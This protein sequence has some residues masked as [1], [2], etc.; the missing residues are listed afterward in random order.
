MFLARRISQAKWRPNPW[1]REGE[2]SADAITA[3]L[4]T[5]RNSLS[6]WQCGSATMTEL[7][8]AVLA[9]VA[10]GQHINTIDLVWIEDKGLEAD[11]LNWEATPGDTPVTALRSSHVDVIE[12]NYTRLGKVASRVVDAIGL[13]NVKRFRRGVAKELL[14]SA[15]E[16]GQVLRSDL[17]KGI[18][19]EL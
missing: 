13:G 6:F 16:R 7:E 9:I 11:G 18:Q 19:K 2:I 17:H 5:Y 12:L 14:V 8:R 1:L 3:D 4:R 10:A 15:V